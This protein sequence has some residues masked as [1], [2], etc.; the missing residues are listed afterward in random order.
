MEIPTLEP[1]VFIGNNLEFGDEENVYF[2]DAASYK[3]GIRY[4]TPNAKDSAIFLTGS[5][6]EM[7]HIFTYDQALDVLM[8]CLLRRNKKRK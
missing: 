7:N 5:Q 2:Q 8:A 4:E 1:L 3:Q 6:S